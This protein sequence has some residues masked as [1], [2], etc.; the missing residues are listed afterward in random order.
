MIEISPAKNFHTQLSSANPV[1]SR[2]NV[3]F[4]LHNISNVSF[5][6]FSF[7]HH[8]WQRKTLLKHVDYLCSGSRY[9]CA[10]WIEM[11]KSFPLLLHFDFSQWLLN[12]AV[13]MQ[14][15]LWCLRK[16]LMKN[17]QHCRPTLE[18][19]LIEDFNKSTTSAFDFTAAK[20]F[21]FY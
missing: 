12:F 2:L 17:R 11:K 15:I 19:S 20:S 13:I 7:P 3:T 5:G 10:Q 16:S 21:L 14:V 9:W 8:P 4:H 1:I 6:N 18:S